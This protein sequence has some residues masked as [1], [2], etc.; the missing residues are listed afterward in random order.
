M[1]PGG[2][3][4]LRGH[5]PKHDTPLGKHPGAM[6]SALCLPPPPPD[7]VNFYV[8]FRLQPQPVLVLQVGGSSASGLGAAAMPAC[9]QA[10]PTPRWSWGCAALG[11]SC[12][13]SWGMLWSDAELGWLCRGAARA[14]PW[15]PG[16]WL[17][18]AVWG[19]VLLSWLGVGWQ[20]PSLPSQEAQ[21]KGRSMAQFKHAMIFPEEL[22]RGSRAQEK[23]TLICIY[24]HS[25]Y[26]FLVSQGMCW[27]GEGAWGDLSS[28]PEQHFPAAHWPKC[29]ALPAPCRLPVVGGMSCGAA[30]GAWGLQALP[31]GTLALAG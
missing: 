25:P 4:T 26:I 11:W 17:L 19:R 27:W 2:A 24:I 6:P 8:S 5:L 31:T 12:H 1:G 16:L 23:Q 13:Q 29:H 28:H 30:T 7:G 20:N 18:W 21:K 3:E 22:V 14:P 9:P 10:A 15:S